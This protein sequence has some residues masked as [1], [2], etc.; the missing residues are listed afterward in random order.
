MIISHPTV[1]GIASERRNFLRPKV[2]DN[3]PAGSAPTRAPITY[4]DTTHDIWSMVSIM[5][6]VSATVLGCCG[7]VQPPTTVPEAKDITEARKLANSE[8]RI[9][10]FFNDSSGR[11]SISPLN[12]DSD[13]MVYNYTLLQFSLNLIL[14]L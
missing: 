5:N 1:I 8:R 9:E 13:N 7:A 12:D 6:M 14:I 11:F 2:R 4:M 3:P 10:G